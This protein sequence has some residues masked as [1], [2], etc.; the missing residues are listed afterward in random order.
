MKIAFV[1]N[2]KTEDSPL[3][4]EF[5]TPETIAA[6]VAALASRGDEVIEAE[7]PDGRGLARW[8]E[9]LRRLAP[10]LV[11]NT[12]EGFTGVWRESLGPALFE[13]LGLAYVGSGPHACVVTLDKQLTKMCVAAAGV[14]VARGWLCRDI[15]ELV[16]CVARLEQFPVF[17]KPNFEGSSLGVTRRSI[18][19][20]RAACLKYGRE[21]L[22]QFTAGVLIEEFVPGRD[23]TV[24]F[25]AGLGDGGALEPLEYLIEGESSH[26]VVY[27]Y[28]LKNHEGDRVAP[29]CPASGSPELLAR[30]RAMTRRAVDV[31]GVRDMARVDFRVTPAGEP[32]FLELNALP[33]LQPDA[34]LFVAS[35]LIGLNYAETIQAIVRAAV[36][37]LHGVGIPRTQRRLAAVAGYQA[38]RR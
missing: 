9:R 17:L 36:T 14:P 32:V 22:R 21:C 10:D 15:E 3:Q 7:L 11:F 38:V 34:G 6:I 13:H 35:E 2:R 19:A 26:E 12:A 30:L 29:C 23:V 20:D 37:R 28:E 27:D 4:A 8:C 16:G 5:D 33:S 25:I 18:C 1:F 31:L 24:G